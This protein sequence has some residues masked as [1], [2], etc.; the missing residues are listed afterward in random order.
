MISAPG[1]RTVELKGRISDLRN[2]DAINE[3]C[4]ITGHDYAEWEFV[5]RHR[6]GLT[7]TLTRDTR[8]SRANYPIPTIGIWEYSWKD[9]DPHKQDDSGTMLFENDLRTLNR[10]GLSY[11][12]ADRMLKGAG[13]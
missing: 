8:V 3:G 2:L 6:D 5:I 9:F 13:L 4:I 1:R 12:E 11:F 10:F 7:V